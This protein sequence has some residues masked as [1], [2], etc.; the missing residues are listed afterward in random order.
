MLIKRNGSHLTF[1]VGVEGPQELDPERDRI[2]LQILLGVNELLE[3]ILKQRK[4]KGSPSG[5]ESTSVRS[6][7]R[8]PAKSEASSF[9]EVNSGL[10]IPTNKTGDLLEARTGIEPVHKGFADLSIPLYIYG[11]AIYRP[12][13]RPVLI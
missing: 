7:V 12:V 13:S 8:F 9:S 1:N 11:Y 6:S 5:L 10:T 4:K 2:H 3:N